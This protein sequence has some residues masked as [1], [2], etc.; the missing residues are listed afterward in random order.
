MVTKR[1]LQAETRQQKAK[2]ERDKA[3]SEAKSRE[4]TRQWHADNNEKAKTLLDNE[5]GELL[6]KLNKQGLKEIRIGWCNRIWK[7]CSYDDKRWDECYGVKS[8]FSWEPN[9]EYKET[10]TLVSKL[11]KAGF[12]AT[13]EQEE[14][15]NFEYVTSADGYDIVDRPGTHTVHFLRISW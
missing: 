2:E 4:W 13:L 6:V 7:R 12:T 5:L 3:E 14:H 10:K 8:P 9:P 15:Q 1:Q 11:K